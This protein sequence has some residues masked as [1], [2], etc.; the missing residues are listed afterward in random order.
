MLDYDSKTNSHLH[1]IDLIERKFW[2]KLE[3]KRTFAFLKF[4]KK[5]KVQNILHALKYKNKPELAEYIGKMYANDLKEVDL[6]EKLD[7]IIEFRCI[8]TRKS[9]V[10]T[11]GDAFAKGLSE[12][13]NVPFDTDSMERQTFTI[14]QTKTGSRYKRFKNIDGVFVVNKP[15]NINGKRDRFGG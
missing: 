14:S 4:T 3:I 6:S 8:K 11:S 15:E 7:L 12:G 9:S 10:D 2:G 1:P 5:G 13:L